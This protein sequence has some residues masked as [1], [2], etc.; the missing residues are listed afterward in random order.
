MD[1][2]ARAFHQADAVYVTDIYPASEPPIEG[3]TSQVLVDKL[4]AYGH[5]GAHYA[6]SIDQGIEAAVAAAESGDVIVALGAGSITQA[7][8]RILQRLK[9]GK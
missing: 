8:D 7:A 5:R 1:D 3:V 9:E 6:P 4:I 2:F